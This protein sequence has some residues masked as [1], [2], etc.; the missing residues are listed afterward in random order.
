M[1]LTPEDK[2]PEH[3][4]LSTLLWAIAPVIAALLF[5]MLIL[6]A[7]GAPPV[8][9][10]AVILQGAVESPQK[11]ADV[12]TAWAP[13][14]LVGAGMSLT[15][16]AGLWNIGA[17]GQIILGAI[18]ATWVARNVALP[19]APL[20]ALIVLAGLL[21]GALWGLLTGALKVYAR[22]HEIFAGLGLNFVATALVIWLIFNP[23]KPARGATMSGTEPFPKAAWVPRLGQTRLPPLAVALAII[24]VVI[25]YLLLKGTRFGLA[26]RAIG[27]NHRAAYL[28]GIPTN[29]HTLIAFVLCG[30]MAG[31]AGALQAT[32]VYHRLIPRISGGMGY[33]GML[34]VLLAGYR[35]EWAPAVAIFFAAIGVGSPRLELTMQLDAALGGVLEGA[36]VLFMLLGA[37]LRKRLEREQG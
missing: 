14:A 1:N 37:G 15:F 6:L 13:L 4:R 9:A 27:K 35:P 10:I 26:L 33:T 19:Q 21:G 20:L 16:A 7:V 5:T 3:S 8:R 36:V 31:L 22:V 25:A 11:W 28:Q 2:S 12:A 24:A 30:A 18:F 32:A 23:W 34:V 29:R 17:E